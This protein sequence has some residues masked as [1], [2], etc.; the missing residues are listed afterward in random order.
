MSDFEDDVLN[1]DADLDYEVCEE[2]EEALLADDQSTRNNQVTDA[3]ERIMQRSISKSSKAEEDWDEEE[4]DDDNEGRGRFLSERAPNPLVARPREDIP[5]SLDQVEVP[6]AE[7][8]NRRPQNFQARGR[9]NRRGGRFFHRG[10]FRGR[11]R[12]G[13]PSNGNLRSLGDDGLR[14]HQDQQSMNNG[15]LSA[16]TKILINPH[17]KGPRPLLKTP[18]HFEPE[19]PFRPFQPPSN[20]PPPSGPGYQ[21]YNNPPLLPPPQPYHEPPRAYPEQPPPYHPPQHRQPPPQ[22][23]VHAEPF[24]PGRPHHPDFSNRPATA[25]A[26]AATASSAAAT[27][28]WAASKGLVLWTSPPHQQYPAYQQQPPPPR[29]SCPRMLS[30]RRSTRTSSRLHR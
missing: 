7:V 30:H 20:N 8:N 24:Y 29:A 28:S 21:Q 17:F 5:D 22:D 27:A 16:P 4:E 1:S 25:P 6:E 15:P 10:G 12:G 23:W 2:D 9:G 3:R 13:F 18:T 14:Y 26:P 19:E 11:G